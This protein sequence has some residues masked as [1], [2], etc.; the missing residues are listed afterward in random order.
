MKRSQTKRFGSPGAF[1]AAS[2]GEGTYGSDGGSESKGSGH[3]R[4]NGKSEGRDSS[5]N[6]SDP[7]TRKD[8]HSIHTMAG[9]SH[10][11]G[12]Q[13]G[14]NFGSQIN[15]FTNGAGNGGKGAKFGVR[16]NGVPPGSRPNSR[17]AQSGTGSEAINTDDPFG[18]RVFDQLQK[19][20]IYPPKWPND[21]GSS[22]NKQ[23][24]ATFKDQYKDYRE[25]ARK[26]LIKAGIIDDP[27]VRKRLEDAIDFKGVCEEMC[28]DFEKV[29]R[30]TEFDVTQAEKDA[31]I[32]QV[33]LGRMVKK[34]ARSAAGQEAP[35]PMDV[36]SIRCLKRTLD[37][38]IDDLLQHDD[39]LPIMHV[40]LWDRTRAIR[41]DFAFFSSMTREEMQ[42]QIYCYET[43]ARF[44]VTSLHLLSRKGIAQEG[45]SEQ[46]EIE[47]LGKTLISLMYAYNDCKN[48]G[49][50]C[51]NEAEFRA[52]QLIFRAHHPEF[53]DQLQREWDPKFWRD[54]DVIRTA[55]SLVEAMQ[56]A[57]DFHGPL[58]H[59]PS[60]S[61]SGAF[62]TYFRIVEDPSVSYTMACFAEIHFGELRRSI[63]E[64]IRRAFPRPKQIAK[65]ITPEVLNSFLRFDT[66]NEAV[67]FAEQHGFQFMPIEEEP[68]NP[69]RRYLHL[70]YR[71]VMEYP[72][73]HHAFSAM[74]EKKRG[75]HSFSEVVHQN[76]FQSDESHTQGMADEEEGLFV[77]ETRGST[78]TTKAQTS[79]FAVANGRSGIG[80][81]SGTQKGEDSPDP[82]QSQPTPS[83]PSGDRDGE[84]FHQETKASQGD[85]GT[86]DAVNTSTFQ[87][88]NQQ[89]GDDASV[90]F[91]AVPLTSTPTLTPTPI[92][93]VYN[94]DSEEVPTTEKAPNPSPF[95]STTRASP[96]QISDPSLSAQKNPFASVSSEP[97][98]KNPFSSRTQTTTSITPAPVA[99]PP[100][101]QKPQSMFESSPSQFAGTPS[102]QVQGATQPEGF[103]PTAQAP[104]VGPTAKSVSPFAAFKPAAAP[105]APPPSGAQPLLSTAVPPVS[106][107]QA[108]PT[109][110]VTPPTPSF[111]PAITAPAAPKAAANPFAPSKKSNAPAAQPPAA[112]TAPETSN[113]TSQA[114]PLSRPSAA[115]PP[116]PKIE[117]SVFLGAT[118]SKDDLLSGFTNWIVKG[119]NGIMDHF[120]DFIV[121]NLVRESY[122]KFVAD[123]AERIRKEDDEKSWAEARKFRTYSLQVKF[124]YRWRAIARENR[125]KNLRRS[126]RD[127]M[128]AYLEK[129]QA[130][131]REEQKKEER[132]KRRLA[133]EANKPDRV[134]GLRDHLKRRKLSMQETEE[135]LIASGVLTGVR[136]EREAAA[137]IVRSGTTTPEPRRSTLPGFVHKIRSS[138]SQSVARIKPGGSKTQALREEL[139][140]GGGLRNSF[141]STSRGSRFS[142]PSVSEG[143][144]SRS[145]TMA[146]SRW[147]LK[148]MGLETM[149]DGSV[150]PDYLAY[151]ILQGKRLDGLGR[152]GVETGED[153]DMPPP[154]APEQ[155]R[156]AT[157][158]GLGFA[159][160][161]KST[162]SLPT[163]N[164][165]E[166]AANRKRSF[167]EM[168]ESMQLS[169]GANKRLYTESQ[170]VLMEMRKFKEE[171]KEGAGWFKDHSDMLQSEIS[172]QGI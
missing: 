91:C 84:V 160:G 35:L 105:T 120:T 71:N 102:S 170:Q 38:L 129:K 101:T 49:I 53:I 82:E 67:D 142:S 159:R 76:V 47:Q 123:E 20:R 39:N 56:N 42:G 34:L 61:A 97:N 118:S 88:S 94:T 12:Q 145:R 64:A 83:S 116:Q 52:Y 73:L 132:Q 89:L 92:R 162:T 22:L 27:E 68:D 157:A 134:E 81:L 154:A 113:Q 171:M 106:S 26:S 63:L 62:N 74:V 90:V 152:H 137:R 146:S 140:G 131:K 86:K 133:D 55:V 103:F 28:P 25:R 6:Q 96:F 166:T 16:A 85:V 57:R 127:Q 7:E 111:L 58:R 108:S 23:A 95:A 122:D 14:A 165:G 1:G 156:P 4:K 114:F 66:T 87:Q 59:G 48:R 30:I 43:I 75:S 150:L 70:E 31:D 46:Q 107:T 126:G 10:G 21:P 119:D 163:I 17:N 168:T 32:Q 78:Q 93:C 135:A 151:P 44:H 117:K 148:A 143:G 155:E 19:D 33:D 45:F 29:T 104:T 128:R 164:G 80:G 79:P 69:D 158:D 11:G 54:S 5:G 50:E 112:A 138:V 136:N 13:N 109:I 139:L 115:T 15:P 8:G 124:F 2:D 9:P 144:R 169:P 149:P 72:R 98:V 130:Q 121:E 99:V 51:E 40:F 110:K 153:A 77:P 125:Q 18:R 3:K 65:D 141:R 36:R 147:Q 41:R 167:G 172:S 37:Y 100:S 24:M 60:F 161:H